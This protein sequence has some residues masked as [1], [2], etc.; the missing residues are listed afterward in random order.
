MRQT[1]A[2]PNCLQ[3]CLRK[4]QQPQYEL[5]VLL[6]KALKDT[7]WRIMTSGTNYRLGM[8]KGRLREYERE[9]DLLNLVKP[10]N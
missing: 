4:L 9:E 7:N 8:L 3:S 1:I 10:T 2:V 5:E 6:R